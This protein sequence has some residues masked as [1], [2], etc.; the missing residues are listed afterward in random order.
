MNENVAT[1]TSKGFGHFDNFEDAY[2]EAQRRRVA[3]A[4]DELIIRVEPSPYGGYR[5]RSLPTELV[6]EASPKQVLRRWAFGTRT[7]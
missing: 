7:R 3:D 1:P 2:A 5:V 4:G 6:I